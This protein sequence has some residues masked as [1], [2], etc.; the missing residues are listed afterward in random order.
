M[1]RVAQDDLNRYIE[2][3]YKIHLSSRA[4][5]HAIK[6]LMEEEWVGFP[7]SKFIYSFFVFNSMYNM[8]WKDISIDTPIDSYRYKYEDKNSKEEQIKSLIDFTF[9]NKRFDAWSIFKQAFHQIEL[10]ENEI[11]RRLKGIRLSDQTKITEA[12]GR[13]MRELTGILASNSPRNI[14]RLKGVV[15][16]IYQVRC[17]VF[18]GTKTS[19][20]H[21]DNSQS[22]RFEIYTCTL[23]GICEAAFQMAELEG[24]WKNLGAARYS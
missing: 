19:V 3:L 6:R 2:G 1:D 24:L 10:D 21:L 9:S 5:S 12:K 18:H 22:E 20:H 7:P 15:K 13:N 16:F 11:R 23:Y 17:N 8:K 4:V 14:E